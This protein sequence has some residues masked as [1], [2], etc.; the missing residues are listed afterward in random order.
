MCSSAPDGSA[1]P[2]IFI[3]NPRTRVTEWRFKERGDATGW[4]THEYDYVVVPLF[5]GYLDIDLPNGEKIRAELKTGVPY[6]REVGVEH[7]VKNG[8]DFECAFI[9]VEFLTP[10]PRGF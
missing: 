9:E 6:F 2:S 8:N 4:H 5:D 3:D 1:I 7:N 10:N